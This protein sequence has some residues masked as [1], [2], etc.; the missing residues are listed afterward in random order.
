LYAFIG[1]GQSDTDGWFPLATAMLHGHLW[2]DGSRPWIELVPAGNGQYYLP[3]PP[4]PAVVLMPIVA[5]FGEGISDTNG[6]SALAGAFDLLLVF[7]MLRALRLDRVESMVLTLGFGFGSEVFY[8]AATGGVHHWT[9]MLTVGF[10]LGAMNLALRGRTPWLAGV[11]FAL[12]VGCRPTALLAAPA[13]VV[14][15]WRAGGWLAGRAESPV[16]SSD[17]AEGEETATAAAARAAIGS[18]RSAASGLARFVREINWPG[19]MAL[20]LGAGLIGIWLAWYNV[21]RFGS[22]TEFGYDLIRGQ[23]GSSV[24]SEAWYKYGI[25]SPFY[26]ARGLYSMLL[27]GWEFNENFPWVEPSWAGCS[28]LFTTPILVYLV[29]CR[30]RDPLILAG[31]LGLVLPVGL[32][33]MHGNPGYAQFGYRFILDGLPFAWLLLGLLVARNGLTRGMVLAILVG[34]EVSLYGMACIASGFVTS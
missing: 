14:L 26:L 27:R 9:E 2:I 3:F 16:S 12:A 6:V 8:V 1:P 20:A 22:P 13:L 32:D 5:I 10:I 11:L 19:I 24:L 15:Y 29:R 33:L 34:I 23:D 30:W 21:A 17:V 25:V 18:V 4:I 7:A 28:V 31:W